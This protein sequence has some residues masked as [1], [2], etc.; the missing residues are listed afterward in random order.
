MSQ[1]ATFV[2]QKPLLDLPIGSRVTAADVAAAGG[3][4][5]LLELQIIRPEASGSPA[6]IE[7]PAASVTTKSPRPKN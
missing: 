6:E 2:T 5:R 3:V 7:A 4:D 1:T